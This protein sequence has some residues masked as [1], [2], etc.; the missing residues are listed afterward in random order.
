MRSWSSRNHGPQPQPQPQPEA[1]AQIPAVA[2]PALADPE[3]AQASAITAETVEGVQAPLVA[4]LIKPVADP[5]EDAP[6]LAQADAPAVPAVAVQPA[7][8]PAPTRF[9]T[10]VEPA[11][12]VAVTDT[13]RRAAEAAHRVN[14]RSNS[15]VQLG[16]YSSADRVGVA[17]D[18]ITKRYPALASYTP[19]RARFDGA[20]GTV[21]RLSI[22]G[23]ASQQEAIARCELLQSRG[24]KCFV[25]R[26]A[27]DSPVQFASR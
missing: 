6:E 3:P 24:G 9:D 2:P 17:W 18:Q 26:V 23:F 1:P 12:F 22:K 11:K 7:V 25:R 15:V 13:V 21:W 14:G 8:A 20:K 27:G 16:A 5:Q 10:P 19:V 4:S